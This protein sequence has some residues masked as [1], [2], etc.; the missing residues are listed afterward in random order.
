MSH[1]TTLASKLQLVVAHEQ[2]K[3]QQQQQQHQYHQQNYQL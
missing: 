1:G 2:Q 3:Q